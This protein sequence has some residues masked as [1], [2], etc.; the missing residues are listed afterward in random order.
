MIPTNSKHERKIP[1]ITIRKNKIIRSD[2][3]NSVPTSPNSDNEFRSPRHTSKAFDLPTK[4][5]IKPTPNRYAML[6]ENTV[7]NDQEMANCNNDNAH[8]SQTDNQSNYIIQPKTNDSTLKIPPLFITNITKFTQFR[9]EIS[10]VINNNFTATSKNEKIKV[11]VETVDDFRPLTKFLDD[12]KYEYYTYRLKNEKDISAI[13]R[14]LPTSI[15]EF[16]VMEELR[17]LNFPVKSVLRLNNKNKTPT[18]LMAIQLENNPLSQDIFKLNKLLN[19]IIITEPRRKSKDPPQCTNCQ[20]YGHIYKLCNLQPRCVKCNEPHHYS[21][22]EKSSNTPPTCVNCNETYPANYKGCAY[23]KTIKSKNRNNSQKHSQTESQPIPNPAR[24]DNAINPTTKIP[25]PTTRTPNLT[26]YADI[27]KGKINS[28]NLFNL[29]QIPNVPLNDN[30]QK[31]ITEFIENILQNIQ[32][33]ISSIFNSITN[34]LSLQNLNVLNWNANGIKS[35]KS[36]LIEFLT[37]HKIDIACITETHLKNHETFKLNGYN[38]YR[39]DRDHIHSSGGVAILIKKNI[40]HYQSITPNMIGLEAI[41]ITISTNKHQIKIIS[42]YNPPNKKI[43]KEDIS[44]VF[45]NHPTILLGDLNSKNQI[46][47]CLKTN[48]NGIKLLQITSE[49]R[50]IISPLSKPT[51]QRSGRVPDILDIALIS[52]LPTTLHHQVINELDSDHVP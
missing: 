6:V 13:I 30:L 14:N 44:K 47:G 45:D 38:I 43:Q 36:S 35:K 23:F 7:L 24:N 12:K 50:I 21:N 29:E 34:N 28:T 16:E 4:S 11:N 41:S 27:T 5:P 42:A 49:L 25:N 32:N 8:T 1:P 37:R 9:L 3:D 2:T 19:C 18:P 31:T 46:W 40:K 15:T 26:S 51:F 20:R 48:P 10:E 39:K 17:R 22:C 33:I 52:N